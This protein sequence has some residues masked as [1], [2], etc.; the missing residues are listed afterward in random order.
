MG[1]RPSEPLITRKVPIHTT[2]ELKAAAY[3]TLRLLVDRQ[4]LLIPASAEDL[5]RELLMLRVDLSPS[6]TERIEASSGHDD[7]ADALMLALGPY[8]DKRGTVADDA[9]PARPDRRGEPPAVPPIP[10]WQS[11]RGPELYGGPDE[12]PERPAAPR[13]DH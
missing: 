8:R 3:S 10:T 7:L 6:G 9:R 2:A 12:A 1:E 11:V 13:T 4:R 5:L